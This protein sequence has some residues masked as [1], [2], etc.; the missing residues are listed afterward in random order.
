MVKKAN[1]VAVWGAGVAAAVLVALTLY[2]AIGGGEES[3]EGGKGGGPKASA[4]AAP[5][6]PAP[7]YDPPDEWSEPERWAT[8]AR[9]KK[10][11]GNGNEVGF[12][13]STKGALSMLVASNSTEISG[14]RTAVDEQLGI[15]RSYVLTADQSAANA[16]EIKEKAARSDRELQQ[17]MGYSG[18][19]PEGAYQRSHVV[20]YKVIQESKGEVSAWLLGRSTAKAG[21]TK[22]ESGSYTRTVVGIE[23]ADGDWK[24]SGA[25]STRA[26]RE[27]Q[28]ESKP[29]LAAPGDEGFNAAGWTAVREAS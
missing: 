6:K 15:Y 26:L 20:A 8:L 5:S 13:Q 9:G 17:R 14:R 16:A 18:A 27:V 24:L 2:A 4:S 22:K 25:A 1:K 28:G 19:M 7:T 23:W 12:P 29:T 3:D 11:D 21:P 10:T